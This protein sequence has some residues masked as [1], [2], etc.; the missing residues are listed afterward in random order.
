[1]YPNVLELCRVALKVWTDR[2]DLP[3]LAMIPLSTITTVLER[4]EG[5]IINDVYII[6]SYFCVGFCPGSD[7]L[8]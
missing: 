6:L 7:H 8:N 3:H 5:M 4:Q 1:M 2:P